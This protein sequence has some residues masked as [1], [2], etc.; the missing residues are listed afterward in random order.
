MDLV[1]AGWWTVERLN[2]ANTTDHKY[3]KRIEKGVGIREINS[4]FSRG[5]KSRSSDSFLPTFKMKMHLF[6]T[7]VKKKHSTKVKM[8]NSVHSMQ[9]RRKNDQH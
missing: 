8:K 4:S 2:S 7:Q 3:L 9:L 5:R 1:S 6:V